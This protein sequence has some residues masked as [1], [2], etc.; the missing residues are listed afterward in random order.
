MNTSSIWSPGLLVLALAA[1]S[2]AQAQDPAAVAPDIYKCT[3]E[4]EHTRLCEVTFK[5]GAK[6]ASHSH[7]DHLVY[8]LQPGKM[9]ITDDAT[10]EGADNDFAVG[11]AVWMPA[12]THHGENIGQTEVKALVIEFKDHAAKPKPK[13]ETTK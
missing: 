8:V 11:Q 9:R 1:V 6:I 4:N 10:G 13:D 7:P 2:P 12:V 5:A 3:F